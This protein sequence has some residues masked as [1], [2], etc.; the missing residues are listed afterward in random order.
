MPELVENVNVSSSSRAQSISSTSAAQTIK[1]PTLVLFSSKAS[2][3]SK[4]DDDDDD[5]D[6]D[7]ATSPE[8]DYVEHLQIGQK[9][10]FGLEDHSSSFKNSAEKKREKID[11][12][13]DVAYV[14]SAVNSKHVT[15][16]KLKKKK[17]IR[18]T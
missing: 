7:E 2:S 18:S 13:G 9:R 16:K 5:D 4:H 11:A 1:S 14:N 17:L 15:E 12:S 6:D 10:T 8:G 3:Y